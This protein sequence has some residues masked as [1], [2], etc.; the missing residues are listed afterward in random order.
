MAGN[1]PEPIIQAAWLEQGK[2]RLREVLMC[3][4]NG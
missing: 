2:R 3:H 4:G 1:E